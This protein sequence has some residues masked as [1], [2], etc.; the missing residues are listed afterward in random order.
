MARGFDAHNRGFALV[1]VLWILALL[2]V[3]VGEFTRTMRTEI[4]ITGNLK[5][6]TQGYYFARAGVELAVQGL[7]HKDP[8]FPLRLEKDALLSE[9]EKYAW[10]IGSE[11]PPIGFKGGRID[12]K[13]ENESGKININTAGQS[14][15]QLMLNPFDLGDEEKNIIVDSIQDWRDADDLHRLYG[16][17]N[18][19]Y[20]SLPVPYSAK[21]G[22]FDS[23]EELLRV[24]GVTPEIFYGGLQ[25]M[26]TIYPRKE[27][28]ALQAGGRRP[29]ST[30][31]SR[32]N[33]NAASPRLLR[34]LPL[35]TDDLVAAILEYRAE[36]PFQSIA[37]AVPVVGAE[38]FQVITPY[39]ST[40]LV[41]QYTVSAVGSIPEGSARRG[42]QAVI[43]LDPTLKNKYRTLEW[44]DH[45]EF[46]PKSAE[47]SLDFSG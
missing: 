9:E 31:A 5:E 44:L 42:V 7:L 35:M 47:K 32:I 39:L 43:E 27:S 38:V 29:A 40:D 3:L 11:I 45:I 34:A 25:E 46:W 14:L 13:I 26:V 33:I 4:H 17:E 6:E 22:D 12:I 36:K 21:N 28:E 8:V 37:Q 10:H 1:L 19:Y 18:D 41:P 20:Q 2:S 16:A 23:V 30:A 15:L 24:R